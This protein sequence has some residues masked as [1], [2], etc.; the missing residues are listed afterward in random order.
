MTS[1]GKKGEIQLNV[2]LQ[3][4]P[5]HY[6][7]DLARPSYTIYCARALTF[8]DLLELFVRQ[9][10]FTLKDPEDIDSIQ[11]PSVLVNMHVYTR[12]SPRG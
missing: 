11:V 7:V 12:D 8:A 10:L 2:G 6:E 9:R 5:E 1:A 3:D 4:S